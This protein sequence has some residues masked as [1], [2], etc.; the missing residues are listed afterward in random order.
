MDL[1]KLSSINFMNLNINDNI[2]DIING[3]RTIIEIFFGE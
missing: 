2:D 3:F 1:N